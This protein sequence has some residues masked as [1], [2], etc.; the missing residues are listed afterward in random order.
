MKKK[1]SEFLGRSEVEE[2]MEF[3]K[4]V[5]EGTKVSL[6]GKDLMTENKIK[7][8]RMRLAIAAER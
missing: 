1:L 7:N 4:M 2:D 3:L 5:R 6:G 8:K